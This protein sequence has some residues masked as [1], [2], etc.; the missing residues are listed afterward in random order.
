METNW[1]NLKHIPEITSVHGY[2]TAVKQNK[3][4]EYYS[5]DAWY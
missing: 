5:N 2:C 3:T 1:Y 4:K